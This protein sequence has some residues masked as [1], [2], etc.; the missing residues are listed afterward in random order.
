MKNEEN[1][2]NDPIPVIKSFC[3][4][5][6]EEELQRYNQYQSQMTGL[7]SALFPLQGRS[8]FVFSPSNAIR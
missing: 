7:S 8:L 4:S 1:A 6:E 2:N 5:S 3:I